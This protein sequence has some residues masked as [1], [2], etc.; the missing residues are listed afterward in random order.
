MKK[1][2]IEHLAVLSRIALRDGEAE[3]LATD[4][5]A[6]LA[7]VSEVSSITGDTAQAKE[8]GELYNVMR[9]DV[10]TNEGGE[11]T[12]ALLNAAPLRNQRY[13]QVKK[14]LADKE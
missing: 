3:A 4:M 12:E 6:V 5:N 14:I 2:D 1:E 9:D 13:V 11:Y 10:I 7:Y 8:V